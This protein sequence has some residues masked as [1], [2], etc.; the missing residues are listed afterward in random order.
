MVRGR[1]IHHQRKKITPESPPNPFSMAG[2]LRSGGVFD[3]S[4]RGAWERPVFARELHDAKTHTIELA[5]RVVLAVGHYR[6]NRACVRDVDERIGL[7]HDEIRCPSRRDRAP[8]AR[9][10]E[11]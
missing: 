11:I 9:L 4:M 8:L 3:R 5:R 1:T 6:D 10:S 7:E 2:D